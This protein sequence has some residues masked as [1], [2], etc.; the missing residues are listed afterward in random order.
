MSR[1]MCQHRL[2][3]Q[4]GT[5]PNMPNTR[6]RRHDD[7]TTSITTRCLAVMT[8]SSS[9]VL[10]G[11]PTL[12]SIT[13]RS[14]YRKANSKTIRLYARQ[15]FPGFERGSGYSYYFIMNNAGEFF[16]QIDKDLSNQFELGRF[17]VASHQKELTSIRNFGSI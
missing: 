13:G 15:K 6:C 12:Q 8:K 3:P 2:L 14:C 5:C 10:G 16:G 9:K 11:F 17:V 1:I 7:A 4:N